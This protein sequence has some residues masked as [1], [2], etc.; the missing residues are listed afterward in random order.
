[1]SGSRP[2]CFTTCLRYLTEAQNSICLWA[3]LPLNDVELD[4]VAFFEAFVTIELDCR[5]VDEDVRTII[6]ADESV[7]FCV[8]EPFHFAFIGSHESCLSSEQVEVAVG[9]LIAY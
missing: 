3:F 7:A 2:R 8:I 4:V 9:P 6:T 1:M 5:V